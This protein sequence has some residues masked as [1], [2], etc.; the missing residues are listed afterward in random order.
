MSADSLYLSNSNRNTP[1]SVSKPIIAQIIQKSL[2]LAVLLERLNGRALQFG[3]VGAGDKR[4]LMLTV[5]DKITLVLFH[6]VKRTGTVQR[7][8]RGG[9]MQCV[10]TPMPRPRAWRHTVSYASSCVGP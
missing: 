10:C 8:L 2:K 7:G 3:N 5:R 6:P 1:I 9:G 4:M